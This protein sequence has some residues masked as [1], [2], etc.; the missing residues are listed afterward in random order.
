LSH[1]GTY[2]LAAVADTDNSLGLDVASISPGKD[3]SFLQ[4]ALHQN[5]QHFILDVEKGN[6]HNV[7]LR[8][9][10][11]KEAA[12][13]RLGTGLQGKPEHFRVSFDSNDLDRALVTH[14]QH[15]INVSLSED[16]GSV[17]ALAI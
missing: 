10:C 8:M 17:I 16:A 12:A 14:K 3:M 5:E 1:D 7:M 6:H 4:E 9:W 2:A 15:Q 11:A 13:K